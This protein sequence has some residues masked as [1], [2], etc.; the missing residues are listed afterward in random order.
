[1]AI[2]NIPNEAEMLGKIA[3]GDQ[4]AFTQ[5]FDWYYQPLCQSV[6]AIT[7]SELL[8]Q[9]IVQEAFVKIWVKRKV[10][11]SI[12]NFSGYLFILSRN[13]C[14]DSL[15]R[16]ANEQKLEPALKMHMQW[17]S[18]LDELDNPSDYYR[19]LLEQAVEKLPQQQKKIYHMSR[20]DRLKYE[21][22]GQQL[23]LS[24]ETVKTQIYNAVKFIRKEVSSQV[25][26]CIIVVLT[27]VFTVR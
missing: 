12:E 13:L 19:N 5:L 21:E 23:G 16:L 20:Y 4:H 22:I 27:S 2:R 1:M 7:E 11:T 3:E 8:T 6:F 24:P 17:E 14:F 18:E 25:P 26:A 9:D 10:L 15:K